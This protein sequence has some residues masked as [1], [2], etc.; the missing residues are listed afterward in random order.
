M[1]DLCVVIAR[2]RGFRH[3]VQIVSVTVGVAQKKEKMNCVRRPRQEFG[4]FRHAC[5]QTSAVRQPVSSS[6]F[7]VDSLALLS[8]GAHATSKD[9]GAACKM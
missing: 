7:H 5:V 6:V 4:E 3:T 8:D 1:Q 2:A 9:T